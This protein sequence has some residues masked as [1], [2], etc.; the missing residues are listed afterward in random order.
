MLDAFGM[1]VVWVVLIMVQRIVG[2]DGLWGVRV[3]LAMN[4]RVVI[5]LS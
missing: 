1:I 2:I 4:G 5:S 3:S